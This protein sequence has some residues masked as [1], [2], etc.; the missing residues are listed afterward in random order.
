MV[1]P[2][3]VRQCASLVRVGEGYNIE[4]EVKV[5]DNQGSIVKSVPCSIL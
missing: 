5:G 2:E 3:N 1:S 4:F